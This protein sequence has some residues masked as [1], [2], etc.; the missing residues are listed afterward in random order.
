MSFVYNSTTETSLQAAFLL[1]FPWLG[2]NS[3][4]RIFHVENVEIFMFK[5]L[6][7]ACA[8]FQHIARDMQC[9][10]CSVRSIKL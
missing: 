4:S 3:S 9:V 1:K 8:I 5:V 10:S 7:E 2:K 6:K